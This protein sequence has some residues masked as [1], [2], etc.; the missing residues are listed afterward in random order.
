[1]FLEGGH[2]TLCSGRAEKGPLGHLSALPMLVRGRKA[3]ERVLEG[4]ERGCEGYVRYL[5]AVFAALV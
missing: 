3:S 2:L 4:L 5:K 1:M